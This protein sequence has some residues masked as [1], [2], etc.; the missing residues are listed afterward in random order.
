MSQYFIKRSEKIHGPFSTKQVKSGLESGKLRDADLISES[1]EGPWQTVTEQFQEPA[2]VVEVISEDLPTGEDSFFE[3][4]EIPTL[5]TP[6]AQFP[7]PT[8]KNEGEAT[9]QGEDTNN[10]E[11]NSNLVV[12]K[13]CNKQVSKRAASCPHCGAPLKAFNVDDAKVKA[14]A[15]F[16]VLKQKAE[17][18]KEKAE[19]NPSIAGAMSKAKEVAKDAV[20]QA[21]ELKKSTSQQLEEGGAKEAGKHVAASLANPKYRVLACV[22]VAGVLLLAY[23]FFPSSESTP[24]TIGAPTSTDTP[25]SNDPVAQFEEAILKGIVERSAPQTYVW[26]EKSNTTG[27]LFWMKQRFSW[28]P[29]YDIQKTDSLTSPYKAIVYINQKEEWV[30]NGNSFPSSRNSAI[31]S[32]AWRQVSVDIESKKP[33]IFAYQNGSWQLVKNDY[34]GA[35]GGPW[36]VTKKPIYF[37]TQPEK[38]RID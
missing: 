14:K 27:K 3:N 13:D 16:G 18:L 22:V 2:P 33:V 20:E 17:S 25:V 5:A 7:A 15:M 29:T 32:Q 26:S 21:S 38:E 34:Y 37:A 36:P 10:N 1:K 28:S 31:N 30:T 19:A 23:T 8:N 24:T 12:C 9:E 11:D 4:V 35:V 6:V